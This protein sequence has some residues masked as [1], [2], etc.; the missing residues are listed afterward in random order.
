MTVLVKYLRGAKK[1][2]LDV[3][4]LGSALAAQKKGLVEIIKKYKNET[5][6]K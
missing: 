5:V 1:G 6:I 2:E 3:W 4:A